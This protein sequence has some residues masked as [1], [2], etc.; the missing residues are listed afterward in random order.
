MIAGDNGKRTPAS[1]DGAF[2]KSDI[3]DL[4]PIPLIEAKIHHE[5]SKPETS[6]P[7][8][9]GHVDTVFGDA[10]VVHA[11]GVITQLYAG[12]RIYQGDVLQTGANSALGISF[13]DATAVLMASNA[14]MVVSEFDY[15]PN[16]K[17][18]SA[19][20]E[21]AQG[22]FGFL[23]G[24]LAKTGDMTVG[25]PVASMSI[26]GGGVI[27]EFSHDNGAMKIGI[28]AE[29]NENLKPGSIGLWDNAT[30]EFVENL[31][32]S[33]NLYVITPPST[34]GQSLTVAMLEKSL[35]QISFEQFLHDQLW[36][37]RDEMGSTD[38][39]HSAFSSP[40]FSDFSM[41]GGIVPPMVSFTPNI[42]FAPQGFGLTFGAQDTG[43][44]VAAPG[45]SGTPPGGPTIDIPPHGNDLVAT[46]DRTTAAQDAPITV[47]GV[48]HAGIDVQLG[49]ATYAWQTFD[50]TS[51]NTVGAGASYTPTETDEGKALR[52]V[53]SYA[54]ATGTET[55]AYSFGTVAE[56]ATNDLVATL[57]RTTAAQDAPITVTAVT[58]GGIDV[59]SSATYAWQTFDGTGW[60]TVGA[61][62]SYTPGETDEGKAL[63]LV[64]SYADATGTETST[65]TFGTVAESTTNDLTATLD[66]LSTGNAVE[67]TAVS[68]TAVTDGGQ[69]VQTGTTYQWQILNGTIWTDI[70]GAT[71]STYTPTEADHDKALRVVVTYAGDAAGPEST[72]VSAGTVHDIA[73]GDLFVSLGGLTNANAVQGAVVNVTAVTDGGIDVLSSATFEWQ[74]STDG[75][76]WTTVGT[77][78]SYTPSEAD[79]GK[80]L[81]L[82]VNYT[83]ESTT[84]SAGV[85]QEIA[86]GDL[87]T[88]FDR[89][90]GQ[91]AQGAAITVTAVTDGG[92]DI[93]SSATYAWQTFDGTS[94]NTVGTDASYT[95]GE[96]D[97][98]KALR[99]VVSYADATGSESSTYTFGTVQE[100]TSNDL[101]ATL[102]GTTA[103][104]GAAITVT[105]VT[106]GGTDVHAV[107]TYSWQVSAD[108]FATHTEVGTGA[109]YTPGEADEGKALRLVVSYA[110]DAAGSESSTY[111]FGTVHEITAGDLAATLDGL[112]EGNAVQG[113]A[114]NV[115]A[116]TDNGTDV[117]SSASYQWQVLNG[118][119]WTDIFGATGATYV[120][121]Q[122]D[123]GKA[124]RVV[125]TYAGD[126][127]GPESTTV[128]AGTVQDVAGGD[129]FASLGGL[130]GG[131][132]VQGAVVD[133][134]AV[135]HAGEDVLSSATFEWQ[136][137]TDGTT[138]TTVGIASSYTPT[139]ADEGKAL[140]L[141]VVYTDESTT[142]SAGVIQEIATGDLAATLGGLTDSNAVQGTA[143]SVTAV[144]DNLTDVHLSASYQWQVS[145]NGIDWTPVGI[146]SSYTPTEADEG[147]AL[148]LVV[149]YSGDAAGSES[150]IVSAG[151]VQEIAGGDLAA[152]LDGLTTGN[153]VQGTTVD[154]T[155]VTDNGE[156]VLSSATYAWQVSTNGTDWT[157]VGTGA[158]YTPGEADEGK[159]LRLV[160]SYAD[161]AGSE[162]TIV[163]AGTVQ[164]ISAGDLAATLDGLSTGNAVQG[165][166]VNVTAVTDNGTDVLSSASYQWQVLNGTIWTDIFGAT[167]ATYVPIQADEGKALRVVVTYAGDA[168][169]TESTTVSAGTVQDVAGGD[170]FASLGGLTGGNAVQGAVVDVAAVTHAG[171][172][173]LSSATFAWQVSTDGTTWTTVGIASSYTPTEAD[174]GKA[175][176]LVVV[177]TDES[178]TVSA[179]VIQEIATGDLAAT[180]GG[181]T[182]SNAVQGTAVSVTAVT[183]N[184]TNVL[185]SATY[186]WQT[187]DGTS[188]NT[189][190]TGTSYTPGEA[191]EGKAL[192]LV[193]TYAGDAAGTESTIVSAG[194]VHEIAA[195][196]LAATLGGLT[197]SNAVQGSAVSVTAVT[198]NGTNVL[199]SASYAW[200]VSTNGT[201]WT[202]V[203]TGASYT[204]GEADEGKALRVVVTYA[205]DAAGTESTIVSAGTVHEIAAG[206]LAATLG[207]LITGNAV[208]GSAVSVTAVTDN[209]TDVLSSATYAWQTFD[210]TSWNTVGTGASYT[211]GEADEGKALRLVVTYAG[212]AAGTESTIVSAGTVHEIAAGD[213]AATL[214]GLIDRQRDPGHRRQRDGGNRQ[215]NQCSVE[216][217]LCVADLRRHQLEHRRHRR[218]LHPGRGRRRQGAAGGGDLCGRCGR[219]REHDCLGRDR[220]GDRGRRSRSNARRIDRRQCGPGHRRQ[221][222]GGD[223]QWNQCSV[224]RHL[225][226]AASTE[227][228]G[229]TVGTGASYT[230]S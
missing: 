40:S 38:I 229:T 28:L 178:T 188:W 59:L 148:R 132:A 140:R 189:V 218:Q 154:V 26:H 224:Q 89:P 174:E 2:L 7:K 78:A 135:T 69:A 108:G 61:G 10:T 51:W 124:L 96:T 25:S 211:P 136:V 226:V 15:A 128:S 199:S 118:T 100:S 117:L 192:R 34:L 82:V 121:L 44:S 222:D 114:V 129:L 112:T 60:N 200:Q 57:D 187:F 160:V 93:L 56:S 8:V 102:D 77:G 45:D 221:R 48:T 76:T 150:T 90:T 159:A 228:T 185:S 86:G 73:G 43:P 47:T 127:A 75:T 169:G 230:P 9:I 104:Q 201:D 22:S 62:A 142:V 165:T 66:G 125:V 21:I 205:G 177:Y 137:S 58:D 80:A 202:T 214:G 161:A 176:R 13:V 175:L 71:N 193:V 149:T 213:L 179:G 11:N 113:T 130:T 5:T 30:G 29:P 31:E 19:L 215:W 88:S 144:T 210:G 46:L 156:D 167:G 91:S 197:D 92:I 223:R 106:D 164:E 83:D 99:L 79:E 184:G 203:G 97:E 37:L 206:D 12:E 191:D 17:T 119:I 143:V 145:T 1:P 227:P 171:E 186:A 111:S 84:V 74:V 139:E 123:E 133:V 195:G 212:D 168:A 194:T 98:G 126:A 32:Q 138:W 110:G 72:T 95:P 55:S 23:A 198:D 65:Y 116:V 151:T 155:A 122:S 219:Q 170:L 50:G 134:A 70:S 20:I 35:D 147:K 182:D 109:S 49:A 190:G 68:V 53:V 146:T 6:G 115:T 153:A 41:F 18:N 207:G 204:P 141:V 196:D 103:A 120:P 131:N 105:A 225:C 162:S 107:V 94:W 180:L 27:S 24:D 172:D 63:R 181:L 208:Q 3:A 4:F 14:R 173:V 39:P 101:V 209:G 183:D 36:K 216:R 16:S 163:S 158:S 54:D 166:A 87:I 85:I 152:T 220:P 64:V 42:D 217:H 33:D 52:L 67:D 81:Q 157:T